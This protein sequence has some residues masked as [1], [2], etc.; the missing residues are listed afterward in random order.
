MPADDADRVFG[1]YTLSAA[2]VTF[3]ELHPVPAALIGKLAIDVS[4]QGKGLGARLLIDALRRIVRA[5]S[6]VAIKVVLVDALTNQTIAFY[7]HF[8]FAEFDD[9][10]MT[11]YLP[12]KTIGKL[13]L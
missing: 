13:G 11:L 10:P 9:Q 12:M 6:D 3:E 5:S 8:G 4:I 7:R 2:N 1:C